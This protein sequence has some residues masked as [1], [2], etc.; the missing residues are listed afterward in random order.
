MMGEPSIDMSM[1]PPHERSMR[2]RLMHGI[3]ATASSITSSTIGR[4]PRWA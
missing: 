4:L 3:T 1:M 2:T